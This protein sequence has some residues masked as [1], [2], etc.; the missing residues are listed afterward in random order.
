MLKSTDSSHAFQPAQIEGLPSDSRQKFL[1]KEFAL[2]DRYKQ[3]DAMVETLKDT[4]YAY[5]VESMANCHRL[6]RGRTC[7]NG[8]SWAKAAKSCGLRCC[9]HCCRQR[10][11]EVA[12]R[13]QPFLSER[14]ENSLRFMVLTDRNC[15]DLDEGREL[16]FAAWERLRRSVAWKKKVKGCIVTFETTYNP[17]CTCGERKTEHHLQGNAWFCPGFQKAEI[18]TDPWHPHLN[19]LAEGDYFPHAQLCQM[20]N[21]ATD[22]RAKVVHVSAVKNGFVD[23]EQGGTSKAARELVKYITKAADLIGDPMALEEFLD[24]VYNRRLLRTYGTFYGLKISE[25]PEEYEVCPDCGTHEWVQTRLIGP[26]QIAM[27]FKG[28]L[29]DKRKQCEID[30]DVGQRVCFEPSERVKA[31]VDGETYRRMKKSWE[32]RK[33]SFQEQQEE[34]LAGVERI[35]AIKMNEIAGWDYSGFLARMQPGGT[36]VEEH[37]QCND[38]REHR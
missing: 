23:L 15:K 4:K 2:L 22:G 37:Q 12:Q 6:F 19:V 17:H 11:T 36:C 27:D 38:P 3:Q 9:G 30:R 7:R 32:R 18:Q 13:L 8:H 14:P 10:A 35:A 31:L 28:V 34:W 20:W 26:Q 33:L 1:G 25:D 16:I 29:R 5:R 24:A 21:D